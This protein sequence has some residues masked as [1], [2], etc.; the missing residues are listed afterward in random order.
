MT[1]PTHGS[2]VTPIT[3]TTLDQLELLD[4]NLP[5][6][7]LVTNDG[8]HDEIGAAHGRTLPMIGKW[9]PYVVDVNAAKL[10]GKG[11]RIYADTSDDAVAMLVGGDAPAAIAE[12]RAALDGLGVD[13]APEAPPAP[14]DLAMIGDDDA[15]DDALAGVDELDPEAQQAYDEYRAQRERLE[16]AQMQV[17]AVLTNHAT[18]VRVQL[19]RQLNTEAV[20]DGRWALLDEDERE[21]LTACA[22]T[23]EQGRRPFG[24]P[25]MV[26]FFNEDGEESGEVAQGE[27]R[28]DVQMVCLRTDYLPFTGTVSPLSVVAGTAPDGSKFW[29][30]GDPNLVWLDPANPADYLQ[31]LA[32]AGLV[33]VTERPVDHAVELMRPWLN[34]KR[35]RDL[36][37]AKA[38]A[39]GRGD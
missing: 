29:V 28:A 24:I 39:A 3:A 34:E 12:L 14:A 37:R 17:A 20:D 4:P 8:H 33:E 11:S 22:A 36:E 13:P 15:Y 6:P 23:G 5:A 31:S 35:Q 26:P 27:W 38:A 25:E 16:T 7:P 1:A 32:D 18:G 30:P 9:R 10:T 2:D 21:E 19:Q